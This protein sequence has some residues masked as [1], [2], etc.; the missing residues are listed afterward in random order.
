MSDRAAQAI[1]ESATGTPSEPADPSGATTPPTTTPNGVS[2][3]ENG[4]RDENQPAPADDQSYVGKLRQEAAGYRHRA[5]DAEAQRD[6]LAARLERTDRVAV[7]ALASRVLKEPSDLW[8]AGVSLDKLRG[9]DGELSDELVRAAI[10][11]VAQDR[12]HWRLAVPD[13]A[14]G[15]QPPGP[16][17]QPTFGEKLKQ[18]VTGEQPQR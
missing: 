11:R 1:A 6:R 4:S 9:E 16:P 17:A 7:E 12:P 8:L 13:F 3:A 10:E 18:A 2:G 15:A 14:G 5:R